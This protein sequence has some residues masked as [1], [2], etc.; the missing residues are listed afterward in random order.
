MTNVFELE[1]GIGFRGGLTVE[2]G[3]GPEVQGAQ[4]CCLYIHDDPILAKRAANYGP[5][6]RYGV[7]EIAAV[8]WR[9]VVEDLRV[10]AARLAAGVSPG[11]AD[12][13]WVHTVDLVNGVEIDSAT[14]RRRFDDPD[15]RE[16]LRA[17]LVS[18]ADWIDRSL[19]RQAVLTVY[20][21]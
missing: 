18:V 15:Q 20:G 7:T 9:A 17:F 19:T 1:E 21:V 4:T 13:A 14:F 10:L 2:I 11:E 16:T 5:G 8:T 6:N 12:I 3:E